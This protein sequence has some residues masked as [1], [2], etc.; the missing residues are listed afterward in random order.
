[1][2]YLEEYNLNSDFVCTKD[3]KNIFLIGDSI[4]EGYCHIVKESLKDSANIFFVNE[5]CRNTQYVITN[6]RAYSSKFNTPEL[7]DIVHINCGHWDIAHWNGSK[8]S[9]TSIDEYAKNLETIVELI[10]QLF[11]NAKIIFATTTPMNPSGKM[12]INIRTTKEIDAYNLVMKTF[13]QKN[14]IIINDINEYVKDWGE[15]YYKDYCHYTES[16][17]LLLGKEIANR[18]IYYLK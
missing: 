14:G 3:K 13:C 12:G 10:R 18:L 1:M 11:I 7:V 9:L 6:L 16:S 17:N 2:A 15:E 4:R 8:N 5:N